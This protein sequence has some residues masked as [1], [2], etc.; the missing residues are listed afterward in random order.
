LKIVAILILA[1][2]YIVNDNTYR[3]VKH[4]IIWFDCWLIY[5]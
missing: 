5:L 2:K 1:V 3:T 4:W